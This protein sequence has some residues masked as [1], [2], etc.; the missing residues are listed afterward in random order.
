MSSNAATPCL[1]TLEFLAESTDAAGRDELLPL[2]EAVIDA[3]DRA[4]SLLPDSRQLDDDSIRRLTQ[5][6]LR[7]LA[8][9]VSAGRLHYATS[10]RTPAP[11]EPAA[12]HAS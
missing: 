1:P 7:T 9:E 5:H 11:E 4:F 12:I 10:D 3:V 6:V 8:A 2:A